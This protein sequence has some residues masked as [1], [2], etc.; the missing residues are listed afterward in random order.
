MNSE[1]SA[2]YWYNRG[3][4]FSE[5]GQYRESLESYDQ[6][7]KFDDK[8]PDIWNNKCYVLTKMGKFEEAI[9][10]GKNAVE[11]A[12]NDPRIWD[13]LSDAYRGNNNFTDA[14]ECSRKKLR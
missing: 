1:D 10:A 12:P 9:K 3:V 7:L 8:D 11:H 2:K 4:D 6:A 5:S 14:A 13:C